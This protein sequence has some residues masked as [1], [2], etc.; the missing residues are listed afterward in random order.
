MRKR[1]K[2]HNDRAFR[3][4]G[5]AAPGTSHAANPII[6]GETQ[7]HGAFASTS[8]DT[9]DDANN[10]FRAA[11][12]DPNALRYLDFINSRI[13]LGLFNRTVGQQEAVLYVILIHHITV[14]VSKC[15]MHE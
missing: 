1:T 14:A 3:R 5:P 4:R 7:Y 2:K 10:L 15:L 6:Q 9:V 13:Q 11:D 12:T 8:I